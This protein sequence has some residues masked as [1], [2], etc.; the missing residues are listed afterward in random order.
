LLLVL[1]LYGKETRTR[2]RKGKG[3]TIIRSYKS[4]KRDF[5]SR[6][7]ADA[8]AGS[9]AEKKSSCFVRIRGGLRREGAG[10]AERGWEETG[11]CGMNP[12]AV[13]YAS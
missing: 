6:A 4:T 10:E 7:Q 2:G 1:Y 9:E 3:K 13:S 12:R 8:F 5:F 11:V